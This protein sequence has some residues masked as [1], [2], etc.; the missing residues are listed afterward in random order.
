VGPC[1]AHA[2]GFDLHAGLIVRAGRRDRLERLCRY[3]LRPPLAQERL[4][5]T[6]DGEIWLALRHRWADGTTHLRF[7]PLPA[8]REQRSRRTVARV[9]RGGAALRRSMA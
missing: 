8:S 6:G 7:D 1:H 4:H 5:R 9:V 3:T 2:S